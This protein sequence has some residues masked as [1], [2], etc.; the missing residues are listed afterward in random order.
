MSLLHYDEYVALISR[1]AHNWDS[2]RMAATDICLI[3]LGIAEVL[4]F[5]TIPIKV[6]IN[7]VV[8]LSKY[9]STPNSKIFV[10]GV[11]DKIVQYLKEEGRIVKEGRGLN[12]S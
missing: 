6:S 7:E 2:D 8:E 1:F 12:E 9:Y 3:V 4:H 11:L 10:N 5:P